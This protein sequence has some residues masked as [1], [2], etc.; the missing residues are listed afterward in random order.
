MIFEDFMTRTR[1]K[2]AIVGLTEGDGLG[3]EELKRIV[4]DVIHAT[5]IQ[6]IQQQDPDMIKS[7]Y[8]SYGMD[9]PSDWHS[10]AGLYIIE[11]RN[12]KLYPRG[13]VEVRY[14][15]LPDEL[16]E[17]SDEIPFKDYLIPTMLTVA[18]ILIMIRNHIDVTQH[19][20]AG[21]LMVQ[22]IVAAGGLNANT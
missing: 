1:E 8:V 18:S 13:T 21:G 15:Y 14:Y 16:V 2:A 4:N 10:A 22:G 7:V 9:K 6:L 19:I 20:Q 3:D 5:A 12:G 11:E 17:T